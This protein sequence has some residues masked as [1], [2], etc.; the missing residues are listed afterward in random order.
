[1]TATHA[2][3]TFNLSDVRICDRPGGPGTPCD[4][5]SVLAFWNYSAAAIAADADI[6]GTVSS[7]ATVSQ[8]WGLD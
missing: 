7:P 3:A 2:G 8:T 1:M 4:V 5:T 6:A